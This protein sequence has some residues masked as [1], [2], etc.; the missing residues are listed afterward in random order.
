MAVF[1]LTTMIPP[2]AN[3]FV[4]GE[5][6]ESAVDHSKK[7]NSKGVNAILNQL[8]EHYEEREPAREDTQAYITL[9]EKINSAGVDAC[10]SVKPSQLGLEIGHKFFKENLG[11][12]VETANDRDVFVW[13]DMEGH[14]TT[15]T[16]LDAFEKFTLE[17]GGGV[18]VCIQANLKRTKE[19]LE[20]LSGLPGKVRLVKGAYDEP[21]EIAYQDKNTVDAEFK[22]C[23]SYM[24]EEFHD[25]VAVGS[26]DP[27]MIEEAMELHAEWG[28]PFELQMLM[29]VREDTQYEIARNHEVW[30]YV[31]YGDEWFSYFYRRVRE[32][33]ENA[34]FAL[35]AILG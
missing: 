33:K 11:K 16:T 25:G 23:L 1:F 18:G 30:Q 28:T 14:T 13:L 20:R 21:T 2:I 31:P 3:Q 8:G 26:H 22:N 35:R 7:L 29:G 15:D 5:D 19:D 17:Y 4:P 27:E 10:V 12:I 9:I 32:R 6:I 34:L 24:F